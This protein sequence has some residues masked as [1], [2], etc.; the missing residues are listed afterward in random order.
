MSS[1]NRCRVCGKTFA[2]PIALKQHMRLTHQ[3]HYYGTKI[4]I[5][6]ALMALVL[7]LAFSLMIYQPAPLAGPPSTA[8]TNTTPGTSTFTQ[9]SSPTAVHAADFTLPEIDRHGLTGR[10][11][12]LSQF[13]G[14]PVF[15]EFMS[16]LCA[17][18]E[19]MTPT[20]RELEEKYG[21]RVIFIS[22]MYGDPSSEEFQKIAA[23]FLREHDLDWAHVIDSGPIFKAYGVRATPTYI[24]LNKDHVEAKRL[25]GGRT[26]MGD[27]ER[28]LQDVL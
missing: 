20:I 10:T 23:E 22:I 5:I 9:T 2:T 16:P 3:R 15:L 25:I 28:A 1:K 11:I 13:R 21:G 6:L 26:T 8:A 4:G 17:H 12:S 19:A 18:C 24:I 27:L 7:I 14:H